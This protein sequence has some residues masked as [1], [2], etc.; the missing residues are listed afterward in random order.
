MSRSILVLPGGGYSRLAPHEGEPVAE[1]L[2]G[3]G[4]DA[5]VVGY[6]VKTRHPGPLDAVRRELMAER[7]GGATQVGLIG[8]SAGGHL[9]GHAALALPAAERPDFAILA[10][11]VVSFTTPSHT[12]SREQLIGLRAWPRVRRS[13]SLERLVT[14]ESPP[15]FV[16]STTDDTSVPIDEHTYP[17]GAALVRA[18]VAHDFHIFDNGGA[19]GMG[20]APGTATGDAWTALAAQWLTKR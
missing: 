4:W 2:R 3:L 6:P 12:G 8:F 14:P 7:A 11:P 9:A 15:M 13:V 10:Y 17:L 20:L 5:R 19:H 18:G 1:W 16:W